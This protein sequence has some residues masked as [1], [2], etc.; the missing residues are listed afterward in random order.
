MTAHLR[1]RPFRSICARLWESS[2]AGTHPTA[3]AGPR[4]AYTDLDRVSAAA[5][6][7]R[8]QKEWRVVEV[9][10]KEQPSAATTAATATT[11]TT[12]TT[13]AAVAAAAR[14]HA[15]P[16]PGCHATIFAFQQQQQQQMA[17]MHSMSF[18]TNPYASM[19]TAAHPQYSAY[20]TAYPTHF[21]PTAAGF[22]GANP[23]WQTGYQHYAAA[24]AGPGMGKSSFVL[25]TKFLSGY[26]SIS[27]SSTIER[28]YTFTRV[29]VIRIYGDFS[30]LLALHGLR[31]LG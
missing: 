11:T 13:T 8:K 31:D 27:G 18:T 28:P 10:T 17:A 7:S 15:F 5:T 21:D 23:Y 26:F 22:A 9:Q 25:F 2:A 14:K 30:N 24:K 29:C 12:A 6:A 20:P 3:T 19:T 16:P 1:I 4:D